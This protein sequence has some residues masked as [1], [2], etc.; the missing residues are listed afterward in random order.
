MKTQIFYF[1]DCDECGTKY[2]LIA[3]R[4]D[5]VLGFPWTRNDIFTGECVKCGAC[6]EIEFCGE[7]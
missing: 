5:T 3:S 6:F 2:Q 7:W 4:H 1:G